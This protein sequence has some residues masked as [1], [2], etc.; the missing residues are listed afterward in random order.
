MFI[1]RIQYPWW[2]SCAGIQRMGMAQHSV[3]KRGKPISPT[4]FV[5]FFK[6][7]HGSIMLMVHNAQEITMSESVHVCLCIYMCIHINVYSYM[8]IMYMY[9]YMYMYI[10]YIYIYFFLVPVVVLRAEFK[11]ATFMVL[12]ERISRTTSTTLPSRL[13][14]GPKLPS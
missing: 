11:L 10:M 13:Q 8:Y 2:C 7:W 1:W 5:G 14:S 3:W 9:I 12:W 4:V 6:V